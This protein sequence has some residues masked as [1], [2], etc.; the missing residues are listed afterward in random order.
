MER[1]GLNC[2]AHRIGTLQSAVSTQ[3]LTRKGFQ[4]KNNEGSVQHDVQELNRHLYEAIEG[5]LKNITEA[6]SLIDNLYRVTKDQ[7][8]HCTG[9]HAV[10]R[11]TPPASFDLT[12]PTKGVCACVCG[13]LFVWWCLRCSVD[14]A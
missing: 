14:G 4:W 5:S 7:E 11:Q 2:V 9:C 6:E 3:R 1:P 8:V 12:V 10:S 13:Y